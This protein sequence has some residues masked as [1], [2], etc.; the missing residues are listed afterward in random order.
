MKTIFLILLTLF[1]KYISAQSEIS[2]VKVFPKQYFNGNNADQFD[3]YCVFK[4][5]INTT[6]NYLY[7]Y[8]K[9]SFAINKTNTYNIEALTGWSGE[10]VE[11]KMT[12]EIDGINNYCNLKISIQNLP[13]LEIIVCYDGA[14]KKIYLEDVLISFTNEVIRKRNTENYS[15]PDTFNNNDNQIFNNINISEYPDYFNIIDTLTF[16][17]GD[18]IGYNFEKDFSNIYLKVKFLDFSKLTSAKLKILSKTVEGN[19][20]P[21]SIKSVTK[22]NLNYSDKNNLYLIISEETSIQILNKNINNLFFISEFKISP[23]KIQ[24]EVRGK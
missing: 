17:Q 21:C 15:D 6:D 22:S 10:Y 23:Y 9:I 4:F 19:L 1:T 24:I 18:T 16:E 20:I 3:N 12:Y 7:K 5:F 14:Y 2:Y 11:D 8:C 13:N